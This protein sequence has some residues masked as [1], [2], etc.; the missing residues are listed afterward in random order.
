MYAE[1]YNSVCVCVCTIRSWAW[2]CCAFH[3][4]CPSH[5]PRVPLCLSFCPTVSHVRLD[6]HFDNCPRTV[7]AGAVRARVHGG[8]T[9]HWFMSVRQCVS[10]CV[11][12]VVC[13]ACLSLIWATFGLFFYFVFFNFIFI[14][15]SFFFCC[16]FFYFF[17]CTFFALSLSKVLNSFPSFRTFALNAQRTLSFTQ[18]TQQRHSL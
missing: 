11:S 3:L 6:K 18:C 9:W 12:F 13:L 4:L 8:A 16:Y 14:Y 2:L 7:G 15:F 5:C 10:V 1:Y 17:S